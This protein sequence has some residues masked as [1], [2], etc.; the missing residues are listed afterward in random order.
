MTNLVKK[1]YI[2]I[3]SLFSAF[4]I[5]FSAFAYPMCFAAWYNDTA[6]YYTQSSLAQFL[7]GGGLQ[8]LGVAADTVLPF[9]LG[10]VAASLANSGINSLADWLAYGSD[11]YSD[12]DIYEYMSDYTSSLDFPILSSDGLF[13][14]FPSGWYMWEDVYGYDP[15]SMWYSYSLGGTSGYLN[16]EGYSISSSIVGSWMSIASDSFYLP[17]GHY[18]LYYSVDRN[19]SD[20][21]CGYYPKGSSSG[22]FTRVSSTSDDSGS[23][24]FSSAGEDVFVDFQTYKMT[25]DN[26]YHY[27]SFS[28]YIYVVCDVLYESLDSSFYPSSSTRMS[29]FASAINN[30]NTTYNYTDDSE[31]VN[32]YISPTLIDS[33]LDVNLDVSFGSLLDLDIYDE[34]TL[35]FTEPVTETQYQTTGWTYDY[36]TRTYT[37]DLDSGTFYIGDYDIDTIDLTYGDDELTITYYSDDTAIATDEYAYLMVSQSECAL[38][39]HT[40]SLED[41][42]APTC[43]EAG[44]YDYVCS[45]CGNEYLETIDATG[46]HSYEYSI[47][48]DPTCTSEGIGLYTCFVCGNQYTEPISSTGHAYEYS[49]YQE[50]TCTTDGIGL[51]TC[52]ECGDQYT[53]II[54]ATGHDWLA[55]SV[56]ETT[57]SFPDGESCPDCGSESFTY[58]LDTSSETYTVTCSDCGT[59]WTADADVTYGGTTYTCSICGETYFASDDPN[60]SDSLFGAIANFISSGIS[61]IIEKFNS[62]IESISGLIDTFNEYI[63]TLSSTSGSFPAFLAGV[64]AAIPDELTVILWFAVIA[65]VVAAVWK[66]FFM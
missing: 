52:S 41:Y 55:T 40:Y 28:T 13:V 21:W 60:D 58:E 65:F 23:V 16:F 38:N 43:G 39:G 22:W 24:S 26:D 54:A 30:Y 57:Y 11:Y 19:N 12:D 20:Q 27:F 42:Q 64:I 66:K 15:D 4:V 56:D 8:L 37:L 53:A 6:Y 36:T 1:F 10:T 9:G 32:Y 62:L 14:V 45:V 59:T 50:A 18:T 25:C 46:E 17:A 31:V 51:Y 49:I 2:R 7:M 63:E 48:Q 3:V 34:N 47:Y 35:I 61:W 33:G 44:Y 5:L 29:D